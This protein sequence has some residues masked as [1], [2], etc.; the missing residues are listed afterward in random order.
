MNEKEKTAVINE[1]ELGHYNV[2]QE[3][4]TVSFDDAHFNKLKICSFKYINSSKVILAKNISGTK[5]YKELFTAILTQNS[6]DYF[7]SYAHE[8]K[9]F[10]GKLHERLSLFGK[11]V[12]FDADD[13]NKG[14]ELL[15]SIKKGLANSSFFIMIFSKE[16]FVKNWT[17]KEFDLVKLNIDKLIPIWHNVTADDVRNINP[18]FSDFADII[19]FKSQ[20]YGPDLEKLSLDII[21]EAGKR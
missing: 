9:D 8:Q 3:N 1:W 17:K 16:Y 4:K 12:W 6:Y 2:F 14:E 21:Y 19:A 7:I 5:E 10:A 18:E 11:I 20:D 13:L 15:S